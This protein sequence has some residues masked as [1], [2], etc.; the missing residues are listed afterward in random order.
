S[1]WTANASRADKNGQ[2]PR[3]KHPRAASCTALSPPRSS[4]LIF[5]PPNPNSEFRAPHSVNPEQPAV[6]GIPQ[7]P[8]SGRT[9]HL[10]SHPSGRNREV[11]MEPTNESRNSRN[12]FPAS[13]AWMW[14]AAAGVTLT[15]ITI[16]AALMRGRYNRSREDV[17]RTEFVPSQS[18][19]DSGTESIPTRGD[20]RS[21]VVFRGDIE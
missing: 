9:P 1:C 7:S 21:P 8:E 11:P 2:A 12:Q 13:R 5:H 10:A 16:P 19:P 6:F 15:S 14:L 17:A 18:E 4:S 3:L 20:S